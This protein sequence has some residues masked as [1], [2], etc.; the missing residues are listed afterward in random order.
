LSPSLLPGAQRTFP[1][2][3]DFLN[4]KLPCK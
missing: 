4:H 1:V 3:Y 2:Y